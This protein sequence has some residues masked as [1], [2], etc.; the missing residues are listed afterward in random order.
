MKERN[1]EIL[2]ILRIKK[3][4]INIPG[5]FRTE[6]RLIREYGGFGLFFRM[7][8][9]HFPFPMKKAPSAGACGF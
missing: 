7:A 1:R 8:A 9:S 6:N 2:F 3:R 4:K 5:K